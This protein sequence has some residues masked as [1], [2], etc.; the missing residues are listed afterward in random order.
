[1]EQSKDVKDRPNVRTFNTLLRGCMWSAAQLDEGR[2]EGGTVTSE[3][4]WHTFR[5]TRQEP[6]VSSYE[7]SIALL[8]QSLQCN[9]AEKRIE[10]FCQRFQVTSQRIKGGGH[11]R[12]HATQDDAFSCLE[13][14]AV[15]YL[16]LSKAFALLKNHDQSKAF[17]EKTIDV[18][19]SARYVVQTN[20]HNGKSTSMGGGKRAFRTEHHGGRRE[21]SNA[22]FRAHKLGEL[23]TDANVILTFVQKGKSSA[24]NISLASI[25]A[26]KIIAT[27]GGGTT[28]LIA[29]RG[30]STMTHTKLFDPNEEICKLLNSLWISFGLSSAIKQEFPKERVPGNL[31]Q[32]DKQDCDKILQLLRMDPSYILNDNGSIDFE[33]VFDEPSKSG[34]TSLR[35][36]CIELGSGFGEWAAYQAKSNPINNYVAVEMRSDRVGQ[37]FCKAFLSDHESRLQNL[38]C[39]GAECGSFLRNRVKEGCVSKIFVNHPEPPTQT[40]GTNA[41]ILSDIAAGGEEPA[42]ML[43]SETLISAA[44]CLDKNDGEM[45]IVTD[46]RWYANLICSTVLKVLRNHKG[47]LYSKNIHHGLKCVDVFRGPGHDNTLEVVLYEGQP[48][49][50]IGHAAVHQSQSGSTY[51]DRLWRKGGGSHADMKSRF[52]ICLQRSKEINGKG[53]KFSMSTNHRSVEERAMTNKRKRTNKRSLAK[54]QRRNER[55]LQKKANLG[56]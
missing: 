45:I 44:R 51:F 11:W 4:I 14:L 55:R 30:S 34:N 36:L 56:G 33:K 46:N 37:T 47:L 48:G 22:I 42:H 15:S 50:I 13:T 38:C 31:Q 12:Y 7:Y 21:E 8:S 2:V 17:A 5:R 53:N 35:P 49:P 32:L 52:I 20:T 24:K 16:N 1:M 26:R 23:E 43:A 54:Q 6:D 18:I 39:V 19:S 28:D 3:K 29:I 40:Y 27:D 25:L 10:E 9:V 41:H